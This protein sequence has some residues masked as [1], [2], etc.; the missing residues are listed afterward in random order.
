MPGPRIFQS[1]G[2]E[3]LINCMGTY[4]IIGGSPERRRFGLMPRVRTTV[5]VAKG[6]VPG[7]S[8]VEMDCIAFIPCHARN[9]TEER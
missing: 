3:P 4:T 7:N 2:V 1:I 8:L 6:G 5:A 9:I